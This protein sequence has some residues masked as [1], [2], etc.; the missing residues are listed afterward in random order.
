MM[1]TLKNLGALVPTV[2]YVYTA[3]ILLHYIS[4]HLYTNLCTPLNIYGFIKTPFTIT[5]PHCQGLRW[6]IYNSGE[7]IINMWLLLGA[8]FILY[9][10]KY[11]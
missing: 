10:Q 11:G 2:V 4:T 3:F 7:K 9:L 5:L 8:W 6:I 1:N